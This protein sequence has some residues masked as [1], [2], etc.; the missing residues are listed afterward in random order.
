[1]V[2][3]ILNFNDLTENLQQQGHRCSVAVVCATDAETQYA[4]LRAAREGFVTAIFVGG[5]QEVRQNPD[6]ATVANEVRFVAASDAREAAEKAVALVRSGEAQ[7]LMKGLLNTD[8][9]LHAVLNKEHGILAKGRVLTHLA[10]AQ[11]DNYPRLLFFTDAAVIPYPT[12]EQRREQV[13]YAVRVCHAFGIDTPRV[14]LIHCSEQ[15]NEKFFPFTVDYPQITAEAQAGTFG[16]CIVDGP[17]D[18]KTSCSLEALHHKGLQSPINGAADVLVFPDIEAGNTFYKAVTL[19]AHANMAC[20]L[21]GSDAP[22]VLTSRGDSKE[23]KY[24]SLA[25]AVKSIHND[26]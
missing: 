24:Y 26:N 2:E 11:L 16:Q 3:K 21:Q 17:L 19:F 6:F 5:E 18:V 10:C 25:L 12:P 9:L 14:S 1:M 20:M 7:V 13:R 4:V 22:V 15:V 23:S 8:V